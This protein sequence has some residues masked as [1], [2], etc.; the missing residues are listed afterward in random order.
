MQLPEDDQ[1]EGQEE[2]REEVWAPSL[3]LVEC[4]FGSQVEAR[5]ASAK[6]D[7]VLVPGETSRG[8]EVSSYGA[9]G[10]LYPL[11]ERSTRWARVEFSLWLLGFWLRVLGFFPL[12]ARKGARGL[13]TQRRQP[14]TSSHSWS[15]RTGRDFRRN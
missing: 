7:S 1:E 8:L 14:R 11:R 15:D 3:R 2:G 9:S 5:R 10:L 13:V 12:W 6:S 4:A